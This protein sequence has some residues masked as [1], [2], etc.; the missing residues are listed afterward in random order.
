MKRV[1]FSCRTLRPVPLA[2]L[3]NF[4]L[5]NHGAESFWSHPAAVVTMSG[6]LDPQA[7]AA[8]YDQPRLRTSSF[9]IGSVLNEDKPGNS[10]H[11]FA[12]PDPLSPVLTNTP[13]LA[14]MLPRQPSPSDVIM[15]KSFL[16][17]KASAEAGTSKDGISN[18]AEESVTKSL[19]LG[20]AAAE[21]S[22]VM[23]TVVPAN[24]SNSLVDAS[25]DE[26]AQALPS[27]P[28]IS[29]PVALPV[30]NLPLDPAE[31]PHR[32]YLSISDIVE[33]SQHGADKQS[34]KRKIG[35]IS[36][37]SD[38]EKAWELEALVE[39]TAPLSP[40]SSPLV[41][42]TNPPKLASEPDHTLSGDSPNV[43]ALEYSAIPQEE[44]LETIEA[45]KPE[46]PTV[47]TVQV[48][49]ERPPKRQRL[50]DI[51]ERVGY[52][53]LGGVTA[54]AMIFGT[55]VYTAPSFS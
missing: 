9:T 48:T 20:E 38:G 53:A 15:S 24:N 45:S 29:S 19:G 23:A 32:T 39:Q 1:R 28:V 12:I 17:G 16:S 13:A 42:P 55:L 10:L 33:V 36:T 11:S 31:N 43:P 25:G 3:A 49:G 6:S 18:K 47:N 50:R 30:P 44:T 54:G 4:A 2:L 8:L 7:S 41:S 35:E 34:G 22:P 52:A 5:D 14:S 40:I 51:A 27:P 21:C 37:L 26:I 46:E